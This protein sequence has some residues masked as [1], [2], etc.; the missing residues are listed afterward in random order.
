MRNIP[1]IIVSL[2]ALLFCERSMASSTIRVHSVED[3]W[4][5]EL[6]GYPDLLPL[7]TF[8][9]DGECYSTQTGQ[10][11]QGK[12]IVNNMIEIE[13]IPSVSSQALFEGDV[14]LKNISDK[15]VMI[16]NVVPFGESMD[17]VYITGLGKHGLS[18]THLFR[19]GYAPVNVIV[20]DNAWELGYASVGPQEGGYAALVRRREVQN[21]RAYR[22]ETMLQKNGSVRYHL[23]AE[24][25]QGSWQEGLRTIFQQ[26]YLFDIEDGTF[27][28]T[29]FEREDLQ[30]IRRAYALHTI[31]AWDHIFFDE[32]GQSS[33][34][35]SFLERS[36][37]LIGGNEAISIWPNWPM[38]GLDQRN[39]W[40]MFRALPGG[41]ENLR[42]MAELCRANGTKLFISYNP[43][44]DA[45]RHED[46]H[47]G[48]A[49]MIGEI[50][51]DGVILDTEGKSSVE[52]QQAA[53]SKR[54]GVIM[55]SE[56]MAVPRDMQGIV[57]GRVHNALYFPPVLNLNKF[58]KPEF[59]I[60]RVA[61]QASERIRREFAL[62][63][64][65]G[66]G[67]EVNIFRPGTPD[68]VEEDQLFFGRTLM[69]LRPNTENFT[70]QRY[71]PLLPTEI[72]SVY[73]NF[74]PG[75]R[76][77]IY[78]LLNLRPEGVCDPLFEVAAA[79]EGE[80]YFDL[81]NYEEAQTVEEGGKTYIV[82]DMEGFSKKWLGTNNEG[83]V[84]AIAKFPTLLDVTLDGVELHLAAREGDYIKVWAGDPAYVRAD[85]C[86]TYNTE[87][88]TINL[89]ETFGRYQG[90][91]VVELF[92][93]DDQ[94][95]DCR[96]VATVPGVGMLISKTETTQRYAKAPKGMVVIPAG[97]LTLKTTW[98]DN[99]VPTPSENQGKT[100]SF[101]KF[102]MDRYPVTNSKFKAFLDETGYWPA[103]PDNFLKHWVDGAPKKGEENFPVI[104]VSYEDAQAYARWAGKRLPTEAEWQYAAQTEKGYDWPW[105]D[106]FEVTKE[107]Q[108]ITNTL[109][110]TRMQIPPGYC[111]VGDNELYPVGKYKKG[112]N[113][114]GLY[115]LVG[116]VWQIT[117]DY[118]DNGSNYMYIVKGGSYFL[119]ASSWW[120]VEGGPRELTYCQKILSISPSF[121]RCATVGFR[122]VADA[123]QEK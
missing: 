48:M 72:D 32:H 54:R 88:Q 6:D 99:F 95:L 44:D 103:Q 74:W 104:Y 77:D 102:Y 33:N 50:T 45:T 66:Y 47:A 73:V 91:Y 12:V 42:H 70:D 115:D 69:I 23:W 75:D 111:N 8:V 52:H 96:V 101:P 65:N 61:E 123:E 114:N 24:P 116:C 3:C 39:Q 90:K 57:S 31:M 60:F 5:F 71:T 120:Y 25:F 7:I 89:Y 29:L 79:G 82:A 17:H 53:D 21:G 28:D 84:G 80:H 100:I 105:G 93:A 40:D 22:F 13:F 117:N 55:Y 30:W 41:T 112:V 11:E 34:L 43:W 62:S 97:T 46:H 58:I 87:C 10:V 83:S 35:E 86:R 76:K 118:Y 19:P 68:W 122:C 81:W 2:L 78:T 85:R 121:D 37:R 108:V 109:T 49:Q 98:G 64:F 15:E 113:P 94:L 92:D 38:L 18:R 119:P 59:A 106:R 20:P 27:D 110:V 107:N 9:L 14:V 67:T 1:W 26:H 36:K 56:G 51:A 63:F 4:S 16:E